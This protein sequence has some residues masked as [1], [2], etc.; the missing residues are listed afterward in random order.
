M[1]I[2]AGWK[3]RTVQIRVGI[4]GKTVGPRTV[5][6]SDLHTETWNRA[7]VGCAAVALHAVLNIA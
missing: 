1:F 2:C 7:V 6:L 5:L 3:K 4:T